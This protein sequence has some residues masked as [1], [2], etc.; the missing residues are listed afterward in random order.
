M[1]NRFLDGLTGAGRA[2]RLRA[3][4]F[5]IALA[6]LCWLPP[7]PE[8]AEPAAEKPRTVTY[9]VFDLVEK[10]GATRFGFSMEEI[11][12][13][14]TAEHPEIWRGSREDAAT[15]EAVND[16][17][18]VIHTTPAVHAEIVQ[19]LTSLRGLADLAVDVQSDVYEVDR[20]FYEKHFQPAV[21]KGRQGPGKPFAAALDG[22]LD[23]LRKEGTLVKSNQVR[24]A[25]TKEAG[26]ISLRKA[27]TYV[28]RPAR[29]GK[30]DFATAFY[31][32]RVQAAVTVSADR[33]FVR[34][35][36]TQDTTNLVEIETLNDDGQV[37]ERPKLEEASSSA[38][39]N[40]GDGESVL[41]PLHFLPRAAQEKDRVWVL[42]VQ[43]L[44]HIEA[45]EQ[46]R[47]KKGS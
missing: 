41:V 39:F 5:L 13:A 37:L 3:L 34:L 32:F 18:L 10:P 12:K 20:G 45:E 33:R 44:I 47:N 21:E 11:I 35:K 7:G 4:F 8:A 15:I 36:L 16:T 14:I 30:E 1:N 31:G 23:R 43:S 2:P 26:C 17:R 19:T 29:R 38:T 9:D 25:N 42:V 24:I 46:E 28:S 27:F 6:A 40:I 22:G